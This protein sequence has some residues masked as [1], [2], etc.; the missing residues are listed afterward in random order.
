L[1]HLGL[2]LWL[3]EIEEFQVQAALGKAEMQDKYEDAKKKFNLTLHSTM[4]KISTSKEKIK[5]IDTKFDEL[6]VQ[7]ELGKADSLDSFKE[8]KKKLLLKLHEVEVEIKTNKRFNDTYAFVLIEIEKFKI[9]LELLEHKIEDGK[10]T[11]KTS[12]DK[13]QIE[14]NAFI[15]KIKAKYSKKEETKWENFQDEISEAVLHL[16]KAFTKP[17]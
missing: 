7:L 13:G 9:K 11:A 5:D 17:S 16:K 2:F 14:L 12:F 15:D 3:S 10:E 4:A 6:R 1:G 8:Q